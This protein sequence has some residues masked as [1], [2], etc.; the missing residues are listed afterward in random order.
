MIRSLSMRG[1]AA[2]LALVVLS[3]IP[4][5]RGGLVEDWNAEAVAAIRAE[6]QPPGLAARNLAI[7]HLAIFHAVGGA[8]D[9]ASREAAALAAAHEVCARQFPA[10]KA[11]FDRR[12]AKSRE[13]IGEGES[14]RT[15]FRIGRGVAQGVLEARAGDGSTTSVHYVPSDA[16]GQWRRV[17]ANRPPELPQWPKVLPFTLEKGDQFRPPAPPSLGS[18]EYAASVNEVRRLGAKDSADRT[19]EQQQIAVFWS[20]F[21]Y[22]STPPGHWNEIAR[23]VSVSQGLELQDSARLFALLNVALADAAIAAFDCKYHY[24][25]WRPVSAIRRA[26]EDHNDGTAADPAWES[27]LQNPP[28]PEYVSAHSTFSGAAAEVLRSFFAR[29]DIA[30]EVGSDALPG[31]TRRYGSFT[32]CA[33]EIGRSRVFGGIHFPFSNARGLALGR[34]VARH[35][36]KSV[37]NR[38]HERAR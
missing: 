19:R 17:T 23:T 18:P 26:G 31:V 38:Q 29:D 34:E 5:V 6:S 3:G 8:A 20:D 2:S 30:F 10:R 27:L 32:E 25:L 16:P 12:F 4:Q 7:L 37:S 11:D 36:V 33:D 24:N 15:G 1:I 21:N 28:H 13:A 9:G 14:R 22:T 35:V